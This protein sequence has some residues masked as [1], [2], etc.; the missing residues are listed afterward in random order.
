MI[1]QGEVWWVDLASPVGSAPGFCRPVVVVQSEAFNR[2]AL[3]TVVCVVITSQLKWA[4]APGNVLLSPEE[5]GLPKPSVAN[6][7]QLVRLDRAQ[8]RDRTGR[9][10]Q[11]SLD[12]VLNGLGLMLGKA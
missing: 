11:R 2:S 9:L 6:V 10:P 5:S 1:A 12:E 8:L 7:T 3:A 4:E